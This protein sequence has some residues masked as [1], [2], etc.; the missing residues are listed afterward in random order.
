L[1]KKQPNSCIFKYHS[2]VRVGKERLTL[3]EGFNE[4]F[5]RQSVIADNFDGKIKKIIIYKLN[6]KKD[7][8]LWAK[9]RKALEIKMVFKMYSEK[10]LTKCGKP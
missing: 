4:S 10:L 3:E 8:F 5:F 1:I 2:A 6:G 7:I 9:D